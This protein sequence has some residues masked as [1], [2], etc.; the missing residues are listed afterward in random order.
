MLNNC[1][2][3]NIAKNNFKYT[4]LY[5]YNLPTPMFIFGLIMKMQIIKQTDLET[6][7][8]GQRLWKNECCPSSSLLFVL[9]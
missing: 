4:E 7:T 9:F 2:Y 8:K 3:V 5:F 1:G 6:S